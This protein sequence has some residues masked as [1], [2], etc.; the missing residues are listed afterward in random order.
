MANHPALVAITPQTP[1]Q[2]SISFIKNISTRSSFCGTPTSMNHSL[3][4]NRKSWNGNGT[5]PLQ[6]ANCHIDISPIEDNPPVLAT[7]KSGAG[8]GT[9]TFPRKNCSNNQRDVD[10]YHSRDSNQRILTNFAS[11]RSSNNGNSTPSFE[12][13]GEANAEGKHSFSNDREALTPNGNS[14]AAAIRANEMKRGAGNARRYA[15]IGNWSAR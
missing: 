10:N 5:L 9:G 8:I 11:Q 7:F 6:A 14:V 12:F 3:V 2:N 15:E 1:H 4:S 13:G